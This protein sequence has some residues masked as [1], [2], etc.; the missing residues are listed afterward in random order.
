MSFFG[1]GFRFRCARGRIS[2]FVSFD[3][4]DAAQ[5]TT[6]QFVDVRQAVAAKA[7]QTQSARSLAVVP[8]AISGHRFA[9]DRLH[10]PLL[11]ASASIGSNAGPASC[12]SSG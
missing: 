12:H 5:E 10:A 4:A 7:D 6:I 1:L 11:S 8:V 2:V 9:G 3:P